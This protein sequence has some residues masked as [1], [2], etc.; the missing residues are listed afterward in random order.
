MPPI[1][2][3]SNALSHSRVLGVIP[4]RL[5]SSR[6]PRKP[7]HPL[8]GR[9]L[10]EWVWHRVASMECLDRVV[11]ATD[12][13][14]IA[15]VCRS[16]GAEVVLTDPEHPSG[17]DRVAEVAEMPAFAGYEV[18]ANLQG[19][20]PLMD[21]EH[22]ARAVELVRSGDFDVGTCA[23]PIHT[24]EELED[25]AAVKV[26]CAQG[27]RALYFSRAEI[28]FARDP[29]VRAEALRAGRYLRHLGLYVYTRQALREW[30][31]RSVSPLEETER[32]EQLRA[33]EAATPI[34]VAVVE[35]A[36]PG[37]DTPEDV[38][39]IEQR[40]RDSRHPLAVE[41]PTP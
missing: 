35:G 3:S 11:V 33:L 17:T 38:D 40:I 29:G 2:G 10:I 8:L 18:I 1:H 41:A 26:V 37:V 19:D 30:V 4:A 7:L 15:E 31:A 25:P 23:T 39:L 13:E 20:E 9:P 12:A 27:G 14:E 21:G 24:A 5:S 16:L 32:L 6:L 22:V 28:P 34:G 36:E